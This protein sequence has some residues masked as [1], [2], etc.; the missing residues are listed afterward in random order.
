MSRIHERNL[1]HTCLYNNLMAILL[2]VH[3]NCMQNGN[4]FGRLHSFLTDKPSNLTLILLVNIN[5]QH[6]TDFRQNNAS[7]V[8][9]AT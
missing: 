1:N 6:R 9:E 3:L 2:K 8:L 5:L 7:I 4:S